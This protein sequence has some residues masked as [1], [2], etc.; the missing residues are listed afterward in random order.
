[1][2][3]INSSTYNVES[4]YIEV[5]SRASKSFKLFCKVYERFEGI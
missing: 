2:K 4:T 3:I 5:H 1:M